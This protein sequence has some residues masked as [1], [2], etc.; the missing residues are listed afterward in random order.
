MLQ[1]FVFQLVS[2]CARCNS[3]LFMNNEIKAS[4]AHA[5]RSY[6]SEKQFVLAQVGWVGVLAATYRYR[7]LTPSSNA[8]YLRSVSASIGS[9][10]T[11]LIE[12]RQLGHN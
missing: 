6:V 12:S 4:E 10:T 3:R 2:G 11:A 5:W 9:Q 7:L 8:V 1:T